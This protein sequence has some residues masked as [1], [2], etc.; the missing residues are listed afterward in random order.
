MI[1]KS[2]KY[3]MVVSLFVAKDNPLPGDYEAEKEWIPLWTQAGIE[4]YAHHLNAKLRGVRIEEIMKTV[5]EILDLD[6]FVSA[7]T[8]MSDREDLERSIW[9][10]YY[11]DPDGER[12]AVRIR[13][14]LF[15]DDG[16]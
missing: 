11:T 3:K 7:M 5:I 4:A 8:I 6:D 2:F 14:A 10:R 13:V 1:W 12:N 15:P 9:H 16:L